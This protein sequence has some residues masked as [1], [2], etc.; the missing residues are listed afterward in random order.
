MEKISGKKHKGNFF[1]SSRLFSV[2][3]IIVWIVGFIFGI[4]L[5]R[6]DTIHFIWIYAIICWAVSFVLGILFISI[7]R[8]FEN[9][10]K[11]IHMTS[12]DEKQ[13]FLMKSDTKPALSHDVSRF[14]PENAANS[15][16]RQD[17]AAAAGNVVMPLLSAN[18]R[19]DFAYRC[20]I[21]GHIQATGTITCEKCGVFF[22][23]NL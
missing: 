5:G 17:A 13:Y 10:K 21:C 6:M 3:G 19:G 11:I 9:Q 12:D 15:S 16:A 8:L 4:I 23:K 20:P 1:G 2:L 22:S 18:A 7:S 14:R